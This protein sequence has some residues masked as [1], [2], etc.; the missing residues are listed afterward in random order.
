MNRNRFTLSPNSVYLRSALTFGFLLLVNTTVAQGAMYYINQ[1]IPPLDSLGPLGAGF[2]YQVNNG[3]FDHQLYNGNGPGTTANQIATNLGNVNQLSGRTYNFTVQH[4]AGQGFIFQMVNPAT[5]GA[6]TTLSWG[7]FETTPPGTTTTLLNGLAPPTSF[8]ALDLI[9]QASLASSS[10]AFS[11]LV[12]TSPTLTSGGG[13]FAAGTV[14]PTTSGPGDPLGF[15]T[16]RL[17]ADVNLGAHN[18][19]L[20]GTWLPTRSGGDGQVDLVNFIINARTV[21]LSTAIPEPSTGFLLFAGA[22]LIL[23]FARKRSPRG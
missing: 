21:T 6:T 3:N 16:Q 19:T 22:G 8:N 7:T 2:K 17:V 23:V 1:A 13:T 15:Y 12:F 10:F 18:W 20:S 14:T 4:I 11:N 9:A 5:G